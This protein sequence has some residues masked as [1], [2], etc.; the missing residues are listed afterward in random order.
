MMNEIERPGRQE[1]QLRKNLIIL[2]VC[3]KSTEQSQ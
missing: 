3:N 1:M 2:F